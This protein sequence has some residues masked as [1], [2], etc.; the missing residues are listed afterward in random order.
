MTIQRVLI[1]DF[2]FQFIQRIILLTLFCL[3][4]GIFWRLIIKYF[5]R[6]ATLYSI[7]NLLI[8]FVRGLLFFFKVIA[9]LIIIFIRNYKA[10]HTVS[11]GRIDFFIVGGVV[12]ISYL[13]LIINLI[14]FFL[15][16][17]LFLFIFLFD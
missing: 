7:S 17:Q 6:S 9:C 16:L 5:D 15:K 14:K 4:W 2:I 8:S 13:F 3:F 11:H 10:I 12:I 1:H